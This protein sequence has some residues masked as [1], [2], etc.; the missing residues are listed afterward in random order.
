MTLP[1]SSNLMDILLV[2]VDTRFIM[3]HNLIIQQLFARTDIHATERNADQYRSIPLHLCLPPELVEAIEKSLRLASETMQ[4]GY[5]ELYVEHHNQIFPVR[6]DLFIVDEERVLCTVKRILTQTPTDLLITQRNLAFRLSEATSIDSVLSYVLQAAMEISKT[7]AAGLYLLNEV[8]DTL[9]CR[10][11]VG[12]SPQFLENTQDYNRESDRW[13]MVMSGRPV[14]SRVNDLQLKNKQHLESEEFKILAVIPIPFQGKV[15]GCINLASR[16]VMEIGEDQR[17]AVETVAVQTGI[18][19]KRL[20]SQYSL[21]TGYQHLMQLFDLIQELVFVVNLQGKIFYANRAAVKALDVSSVEDVVGKSGIEFI[22]EKSLADMTEAVAY[23]SPDNFHDL[24]LDFISR[25]G[26]HFTVDTRMTLGVW[27]LEPVIISSCR[28]VTQRAQH[29]Q[30]EMYQ[31]LDLIERMPLPV[32]FVRP[33]TLQ[34]VYANMKAGEI[35]GFTQQDL[36]NHAFLSYFSETENERLSTELRSGGI[37]RISLTNPWLLLRKDHSSFLADLFGSRVLWQDEEMMIFV[38][39]WLDNEGQNHLGMDKDR[40]REVINQQ[41]DLVIRFTPDG[42]LSFVNQTYCDFFNMTAEQLIGSHM[43]AHVHHADLEFVLNHFNE[44][45]FTN[46]ILRNRN[47]MTDGLGRIRL[48][49]WID[50]GIFDGE[51]LV[52]IQAVGRDITDDTVINRTVPQVEKR[53]RTLVEKIPA[54][55][56]IMHAKTMFPLYLSPQFESMTGKAIEDIYA[57]P[58]LWPES[59]HPDDRESVFEGINRRIIGEDHGEPIEYRYYHRD[60]HMIWALDYGSRIEAEDGTVLLQGMIQDISEM[61]RMHQRLDYMIGF[62][63]LVNELSLVLMN[64]T[65][66]SLD[67]SLQGVLAKLGTFNQVDRVYIFDIISGKE[68]MCNTYEWCAPEIPPHMDFLQYLPFNS[69]PWGITKIFN[70]EPVH[71]PDTSRLAPEATAE[72][73]FLESEDVLSVLVVPMI[74]QGQVTGVIGFDS[75]IQ[76]KSWDAEAITLLR[77]VSDMIV[78]TRSR[79]KTQ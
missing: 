27:E 40:Y 61:K 14:Y 48:M 65:A 4:P 59:I 63:H 75:V 46:P 70:Q 11:S 29:S 1:T 26:K 30:D 60:G 2:A 72:R 8:G 28:P 51:N 17:R 71:I 31:M 19:I 44:L 74:D 49:E 52:E 21:Q 47:R 20:Q 53:F 78:N 16:Q 35:F 54:M 50:R 24:Q 55:T 15:I 69:L 18:T 45:T 43:Q 6:Y 12:I 57:Q 66:A 3:D 36:H 39:S 23:I 42:L 67:A 33:N 77:M 34:I 7:H 22:S 41:V 13:N 58:D 79:F 62:E 38:I 10:A 76:P 68:A 64:T 25:T 32:L 73:L 56:Y 5:G 37:Q 9:V